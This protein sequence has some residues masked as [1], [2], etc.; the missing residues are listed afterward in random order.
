MS[1]SQQRLPPAPSMRRTGRAQIDT[2]QVTLF[3]P[4]LVLDPAF[5]RAAA[6]ATSSEGSLLDLEREPCGAEGTPAPTPGSLLLRT[7]I[8]D[9]R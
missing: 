8:T 9:R 3:Q 2:S 5:P 7:Q 1:T 6:S 4:L